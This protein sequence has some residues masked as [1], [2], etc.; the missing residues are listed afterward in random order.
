MENKSRVNVFFWDAEGG[1]HSVS[2]PTE[3]NRL[4][5]DYARNLKTRSV[6]VLREV[7]GLF[8]QVTESDVTAFLQM[9][10]LSARPN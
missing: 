1:T 4:V 3:V 6:D 10:T 5:N 7:L 9:Q 2:L 8:G